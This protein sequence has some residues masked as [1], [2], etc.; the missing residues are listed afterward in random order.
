MS[1]FTYPLDLACLQA[2][3]IYS[4]IETSKNKMLFLQFKRKLCETLVKPYRAE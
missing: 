3:A 1:V 4:D 2:Y